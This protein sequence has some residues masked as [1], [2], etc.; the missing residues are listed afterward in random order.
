MKKI[1]SAELFFNKKF[2]GNK[3]QSKAVIIKSLLKVPK[4]FNPEQLI[5]LKTGSLAE[6]IK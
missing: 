4:Q 3:D 2:L 6:K 5:E 1:K